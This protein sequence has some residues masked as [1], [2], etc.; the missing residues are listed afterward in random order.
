MRAG[1][2]A[3]GVQTVE[4]GIQMVVV[5]VAWGEGGGVW[6]SRTEEKT[7]EKLLG[8]NAWKQDNMKVPVRLAVNSAIGVKKLV[9]NCFGK[10]I[11]V[12]NI[13]SGNFCNGTIRKVVFRFQP[14]LTEKF[15]IIM[16]FSYLSTPNITPL[17]PPKP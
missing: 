6:L 7:R 17:F 12:W 8:W 4:Q 2:Q 9:I 14:D 1:N 15:R 3:P 11:V 16:P 5:V 13:F 10:K